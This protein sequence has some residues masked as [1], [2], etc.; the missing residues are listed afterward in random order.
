[1]L[2][3]AEN[4]VRQ[5]PNVSIIM[6]ED[7]EKLPEDIEKRPPAN[8]SSEIIREM[9]EMNLLGN[10]ASGAY[11]NNRQINLRGMGPENTLILIDWKPVMSRN[12]TRMSRDGERNTRGDGDWVPAEAVQRIEILCGPAAARCG[13]GAAG[14][15]ARAFKARRTSIS[16][17]RPICI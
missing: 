8:D 11:G 13:L 4:E 15:V 10:N 2:G 1:V 14:G 5:M 17:A 16:L 7:I 12:S 9:P 6:S 3:T